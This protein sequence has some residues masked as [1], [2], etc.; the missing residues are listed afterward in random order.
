MKTLVLFTLALCCVMWFEP[1][2]SQQAE[3]ESREA[4]SGGDVVKETKEAVTI[5]GEYSKQKIEALRKN[6][7]AE[8]ELLENHYRVLEDT[9]ITTGTKV[10]KD[11]EQR[12]DKLHKDVDELQGKLKELQQGGKQKWEKL[13]PEISR[14]VTRTRKRSRAIQED[15]DRYIERMSSLTEKQ[16]EYFIER[17]SER[18]DTLDKK[19]SQVRES[20]SQ[21][22]EETSTFL[23]ERMETLERQ[24][25]Q[26]E[27]KVEE[28]KQ[29]QKEISRDLREGALRA[30][31]DFDA[32]MNDALNDL[33]TTLEPDEKQ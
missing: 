2:S 18:M 28:L 13:Q 10:R 16:R 31:D 19:L 24:K 6:L 7:A 15:I 1:A 29:E 14:L 33:R 23:R 25:E 21:A 20:A 9:V 8:F 26:A 4:V 12:L 3:A 27:K 32:A 30:L 5:T 22:K 11:L 17:L